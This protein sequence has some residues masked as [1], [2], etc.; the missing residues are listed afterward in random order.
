MSATY[1]PSQ[2][3]EL[4]GTITTASVS[5]FAEG[6]DDRINALLVAGTGITKTYDD[7]SG[8]MTLAATGGGAVGP[9]LDLN[10]T[11]GAAGAVNATSHATKGRWP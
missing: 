2:L 1:V 6:V 11:A 9:T 7:A 4:T 8:T 3:S 10:T 5:D